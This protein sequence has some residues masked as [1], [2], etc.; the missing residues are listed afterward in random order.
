MGSIDW[1]QF[2]IGDP[3]GP[4]SF[5]ADL[6]NSKA[7][8]G[9]G[10]V[11]EAFNAT[12]VGDPPTVNAKGELVLDGNDTIAVNNQAATEVI[13]G[14]GGINMAEFAGNPEDFTVVKYAGGAVTVT[15]KNTGQTTE[16]V[17]MAYVNIIPPGGENSGIIYSLS[18]IRFTA[19]GKDTLLGTQGP[20]V[21][22]GLTS[23]PE[24]TTT[25]TSNTNTFNPI[26]NK[27]PGDAPSSSS[28]PT[29]DNSST[30]EPETGW[31][32]AVINFLGDIFE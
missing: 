7:S 27:G 5:S 14:G 28:T 13:F 15:D 18:D 29:V 11:V 19:D 9:G 31:L 20:S 25:G 24:V 21:V 17:D 32:D 16:L 26:S 8:I 10:S 23:Q 22:Y 2:N 1:S 12:I 3:N 30:P 4:D 6:L